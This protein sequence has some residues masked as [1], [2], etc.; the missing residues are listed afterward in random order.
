M[1]DVKKCISG[2]ALVE[3]GVYE[4]TFVHVRGDRIYANSLAKY[5]ELCLTMIADFFKLFLYNSMGCIPSLYHLY[6]VSV[7]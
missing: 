2:V 6:Q 4:T 5:R 1:E 3:S 7:L